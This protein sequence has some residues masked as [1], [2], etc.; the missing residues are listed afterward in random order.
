MIFLMKLASPLT[1]TLEIVERKEAIDLTDMRGEPQ[2]CDMADEIYIEKESG[3][4]KKA[5]CYEDTYGK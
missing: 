5:S 1:L 2:E 4:D 3:M